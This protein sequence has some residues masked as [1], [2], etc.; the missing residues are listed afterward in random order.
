MD[1]VQLDKA[2]LE[3]YFAQH[4]LEDTTVRKALEKFEGAFN[5]DTSLPDVKKLEQ[6][7]QGNVPPESREY[8]YLKLL[9]YVVDITNRNLPVDAEESQALLASLHSMEDS[10]WAETAVNDLRSAFYFL[11]RWHPDPTPGPLF[12][13][14]SVRY[15]QTFR[16]M[17]E[18]AGKLIIT[19]AELEQMQK[20][21]EERKMEQKK[22]WIIGG[23]IFVIGFHLVR[24]LL[25]LFTAG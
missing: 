1:I 23:I 20:R 25:S 10:D 3:G 14:L 21:S 22:K 6:R 11:D 16:E 19:D 24:F 2:G 9:S 13:Q 4:S 5:S 15:K 17:C 12:Q 7:L 18:A 8:F